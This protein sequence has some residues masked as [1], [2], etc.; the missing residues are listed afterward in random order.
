MSLSVFLRSLRRSFLEVMAWSCRGVRAADAWVA[1]R[2]RLLARV[3]R[4]S[5]TSSEERPT[6]GQDHDAN[7]RG[8]ADRSSGL[9]AF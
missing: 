8:L 3:Q 6:P 4:F 5:R 7:P 2:A 1:A 9:G